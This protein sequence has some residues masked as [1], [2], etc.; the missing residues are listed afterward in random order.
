MK[1][2]KHLRFERE[3]DVREIRVIEE[4]N[5]KRYVNVIIDYDCIKGGE[6]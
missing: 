2:S 5:R 4:T 3:G 1:I 6:K